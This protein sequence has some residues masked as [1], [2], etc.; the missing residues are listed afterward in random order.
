MDGVRVRHTTE[1][2][3]CRPDVDLV[4]DLLSGTP[5]RRAGVPILGLGQG[6]RGVSGV[7]HD[8]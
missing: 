6:R 8:R 5:E 7:L 4:Y 3:G 1:I 2:T